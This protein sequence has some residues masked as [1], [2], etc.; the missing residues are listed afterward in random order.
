ML[1]LYILCSKVINWT[2]VSCASPS[3][4]TTRMNDARSSNGFQWRLSPSMT[5]PKSLYIPQNLCWSLSPHSLTACFFPPDPGTT[6]PSAS[7]SARRT[8]WRYMVGTWHGQVVTAS[9]VDCSPLT[10]LTGDVIALGVDANWRANSVLPRS[11]PL[12]SFYVEQKLEKQS[13]S[14][15]VS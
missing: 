14:G 7:Y 10:A 5:T 8:L 9:S 3:R 13:F 2:F 15:C 12:T 1:F 11:Q 4:H 6:C